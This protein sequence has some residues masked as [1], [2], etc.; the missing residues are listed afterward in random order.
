MVVQG[1]VQFCA[2]KDGDTQPGLSHL[3]EDSEIGRCWFAGDKYG[4]IKPNILGFAL[5]GLAP[6]IFKNNLL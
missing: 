1:A 5:S 6:S 3:E 4:G 2:G